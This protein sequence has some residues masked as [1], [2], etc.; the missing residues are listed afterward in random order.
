[1]Q[2]RLGLRTLL[3]TINL[4][5]FAALSIWGAPNQVLAMVQ[6]EG[7]LQGFNPWNNPLAPMLSGPRLFAIGLNAPAF[8][9]ATL[10]VALA[11]VPSLAVANSVLLLM[12]PFVGLFWWQTGR[13][14]DRRMG[15][16]PA[17][18]APRKASLIVAMILTVMLFFLFAYR[19]VFFLSGGIEGWHGETPIAAAS[20]YGMTAWL[21]MWLL[22]LVSEMRRP[23]Q[24]T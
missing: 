10:T 12:A 23:N 17:R 1:M 19:S 8:A 3:P 22:M 6:A 15:L 16:F 7:T 11:R 9:A 18:P 14:F 21:A 24:P 5:L 2:K 13:W 20:A 4:L